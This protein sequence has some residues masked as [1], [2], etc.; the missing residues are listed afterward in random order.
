MSTGTQ[1]QDPIE[2]NW[3]NLNCKYTAA[4]IVEDPIEETWEITPCVRESPTVR[5]KQ[6]RKQVDPAI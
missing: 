5:Q 4:H 6:A 2:Q 1:V 3:G